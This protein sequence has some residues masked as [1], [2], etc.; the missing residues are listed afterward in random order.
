[1]N[2]QYVEVAVFGITKPEDFASTQRR[3][4]SKLREVDG[5]EHS[6]ALQG[7]SDQ[8]LFADIVLWRDEASAA[9]AAQNLQPGGEWEWYSAP[10]SD[11]RLFA[12][13]P[14]STTELSSALSSLEKAPVIEVVALKPNDPAGFKEAHTKVHGQYLEEMDSIVTHIRL[15]ENAE[16]LTG[17]INGWTSLEATETAFQ[18][19]STN[20]ELAHVFSE[21]NDTSLFA[22]FTINRG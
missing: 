22:N 13:F 19:L 17:D 2:Q 8:T 21:Q 5:C 20:K 11:L 15:E 4:H 14:A 3:L 12:H 6:L 18:T 9:V 1:M 10:A 16:G 7:L